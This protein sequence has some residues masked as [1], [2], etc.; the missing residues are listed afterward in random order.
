[1]RAAWT[2]IGKYN[3]LFHGT[4]T[5]V[6]Y[7]WLLLAIDNVLSFSIKHAFIKPQICDQYCARK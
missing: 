1:M 3:C 6:L 2:T 7:L 5:A 4:G